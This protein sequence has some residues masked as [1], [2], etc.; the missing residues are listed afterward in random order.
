MLRKPG[1][2]V[3]D[4]GEAERIAEECRHRGWLVMCLPDGVA[5]KGQFFDA[6][7]STCPLDP[8]LHSNRSWD[9][10]SDSLWSGL[11]EVE[12]EEVAIFLAQFRPDENSSARVF[13]YRD[14]YIR[15]FVYFVG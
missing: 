11:D 13:R 3:V 2:Y 14:R 8:P 15:R 5:S 7:R 10:L 1:L 4:S 6:I 9:A 12:E